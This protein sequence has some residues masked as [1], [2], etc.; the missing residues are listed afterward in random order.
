MFKCLFT[1][2]KIRTFAINREF[3]NNC[4]TKVI[5]DLCLDYT[6]QKY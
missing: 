3:N 6:D 2:V 1:K 4:I 5:F